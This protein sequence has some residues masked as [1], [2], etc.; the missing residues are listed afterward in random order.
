MMNGE[1][2]QVFETVAQA[3]MNQHLRGK[4]KENGGAVVAHAHLDRAWTMKPEW[5]DLASSATVQQKWGIVDEIKREGTVESIRDRMCYQIESFIDQGVSVVST[6]ID[7]DSVVGDKAMNAAFQARDRYKSD[8]QIV[9]MNQ[10]LKGLIDHEERMMF[11][12]A[13]REGKMVH[14]HVDQNNRPQERE[15]ELL[16]DAIDA[17]PEMKGKVVAIHGLS[18]A[19]EPKDYRE[20]IYRRSADSGLI[21]V[22]CPVAWSDDRRSE[23]LAPI[24]NPITPWD[25]MKKFGVRV[26]VGTDNIADIYCPWNRGDMMEEMR[27]LARST[28]TN[29]ISGLVEV[30]TTNGR[31]SLGLPEYASPRRNGHIPSIRQIS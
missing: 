17:H 3:D 26:A 30:A 25:E 15:T 11:D 7:Y 6:F 22:S 21:F 28:R 16:L 8:V 27:T 13:K 18:V 31:M 12:V 10:T 24:H 29:D 9:L 23:T 4:I 14:A 19:A 20:A 1:L 2:D 5:L